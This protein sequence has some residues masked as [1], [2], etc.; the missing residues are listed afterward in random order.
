MKRFLVLVICSFLMLSGCD[1]FLSKEKFQIIIKDD[2]FIRLNKETGETILLNK[3]GK[4]INVDDII[5]NKANLDQ[6]PTKLKTDKTMTFPGSSEM[7]AT[8]QYKWVDSKLLFRYEFG[9]YAEGIDKERVES[10]DSF[11]VKFQDADGFDVLESRIQLA[12][13]IRTM[14]NKNS[15]SHWN[16]E[17]KI[18]CDKKDFNQIAY[19]SP[20]WSFSKK[21]SQQITQ[22]DKDLKLSKKESEKIITVKPAENNNL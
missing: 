2:I 17:S 10:S 18:S 8:L 21:M 19:Y 22:L 14:G 5:A 9:P 13:L 7:W 20:Q 4:V 1:Q 15:P 16:Y 11:I 3:D 12:D 6:S